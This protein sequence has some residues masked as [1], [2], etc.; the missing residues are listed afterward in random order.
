MSNSLYGGGSPDANSSATGTTGTIALSKLMRSSG[1]PGVLTPGS[2]AEPAP[3]EP[4]PV[5]PVP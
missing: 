3:V 1:E 2:A 5:E 4:V